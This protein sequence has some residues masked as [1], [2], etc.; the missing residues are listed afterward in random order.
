MH[1]CE[2]QA[3]IDSTSRKCSGRVQSTLRLCEALLVA[4]SGNSSS[5]CSNDHTCNTSGPQAQSIRKLSPGSPHNVQLARHDMLW[6]LTEHQRGARAAVVT[7]GGSTRPR[8]AHQ[9]PR[10]YLATHCCLCNAQPA[11]RSHY[12]ARVCLVYVA[13]SLTEPGRLTAGACAQECLQIARNPGCAA[14]SSGS[15]TRSNCS[16][17]FSTAFTGTS[18]AG[19]SQAGTSQ[20]LHRHCL[21]RHF[22]G[23]SHCL[24]RQ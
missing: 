10:V 12:V 20:A 13:M 5:W 11:T 23:T 2:V 24:H 1:L 21:H 14:M 17:T 7:F 4:K 19:T 22:T 9:K 16:R 15:D 8:C 18:Q 6:F 3:L